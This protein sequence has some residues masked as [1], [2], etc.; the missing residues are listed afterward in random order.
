MLRK[1]ALEQ[2]LIKQGAVVPFNVTP[3]SEVKFA[4]ALRKGYQSV[5]GEDPSMEILGGAWAQ[6]ILESGRPVKLPNNNVGNIKATNDWKKSNN[7][8]VKGTVEFDGSGNKYSAPG[9]EW[10][11]YDSPEEGAV[12]YWE[13]IG[14]KRYKNAMDWMA[15]GDPESASVIFGLTGYYTANIKRYSGE[16]NKL[17]QEFINKIAPNLSG[18]KSDVAPPPGEK[19]DAKNWKSEYSEEEKN[20]IL[21]A[22]PK[23]ASKLLAKNE[24]S[25]DNEIESLIKQLVAKNNFENIMKFAKKTSLPESDVL[26][27]VKTGSYIHKLEYARILSSMLKQHLN[28]DARVCVN[29]KNVE[30]QCCGIGS[31]NALSGAIKEVSEITHNIMN[32]KVGSNISIIMMPGFLS[33]YGE[34]DFDELIKNNKR[35]NM[36]RILNGC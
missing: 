33:K 20:M 2:I 24:P 12:G 15:A 30:L 9:A 8:F 13:L 32:K 3:L 25:N 18:L 16:V 11:A 14:N 34:I 27:Y 26:V 4:D 19:P 17:Y 5:Y 7:Y 6:A 36:E 31:E 28:V 21:N 1:K 22:G 29:E 10:R 23:D 35:F